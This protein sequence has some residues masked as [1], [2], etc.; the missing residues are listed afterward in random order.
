MFDINL[1]DKNNFFI[2]YLLTASAWLVLRCKSVTRRRNL[3]LT[4][5]TFGNTPP[6]F[7]YSSEGNEV[8]RI[9]LFDINN[10]KIENN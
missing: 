5:V 1:I 7:M 2:L 8:Q 10:K 9:K 6:T 4:S 3:T